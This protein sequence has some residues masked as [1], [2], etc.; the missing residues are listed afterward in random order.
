MTAFVF[1]NRYL[2]EQLRISNVAWEYNPQGIN[3]GYSGLELVPED[4][5]KIGQLFL[6][7]G[8]WNGERIVSAEWVEK[9]T[10]KR[11]KGTLQEG[12]GYHW[13]LDD[14]G[15]YMALGYGGQYLMVV[16]E[17]NLV[18]VFVSDL[19]ENDFYLPEQLLHSYILPAIQSS[20]PLPEDKR[21]TK[22]LRLY[23]LA[24]RDG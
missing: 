2:F 7:G 13:W 19:A 11:I 22:L 3:L 23:R 21:A 17:E 18:V 6:S 4:L 12:Y 9:S 24:L 5:A 1:A 14:S 15:I 16:P 10:Q 20:Q 8:L